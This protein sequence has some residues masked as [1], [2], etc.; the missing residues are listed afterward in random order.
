MNI[1]IFVD[2]IAYFPS[3]SMFWAIFVDGIAYF[4]SPSTFWA[5]FVD[6]R[7]GFCAYTE[8][9]KKRK[10]YYFFSYICDMHTKPHN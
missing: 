10:D 8:T 2:G 5:I 4:P 3:P 9:S 7:G 1:C 6:G